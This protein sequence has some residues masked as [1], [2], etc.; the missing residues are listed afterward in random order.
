MSDD[1]LMVHSI[2]SSTLRNAMRFSHHSVQGHYHGNFGIEWFGD[3]KKSRW[4]MSV[5]CLM[6]P[7]SSAAR[8]G[9]SQVFK[10]PILGCG[11]IVSDQ[12]NTLILPDIHFPYHHKDTFDFLESLR[13]YYN[14][15]RVLCVGDIF[16]NHRP[17]Y[18]ESEGDSLSE[19]DE[20]LLAK[21]NAHDLKEL[22]P[23]MVI[24]RGNHDDLP[25]RKAKSA[26]LPVSMLSDMN[27]LY[28]LG[29]GWRWVHEHYFDSW[30]G[31]PVV[32]PFHRNK[33]GRWTKTF[34][35]L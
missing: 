9:R 19:E 24:A 18:H 7:E 20:Y 1:C 33:R 27:A 16:D 34:T 22:F 15:E 26:K 29:D 21:R 12:G 31:D 17:S 14:P 25:V 5:G 11:L 8:Y 28:D 6:D 4:S 23:Q 30:S 3:V 2:S 35:R 32:I 13:D 10:V